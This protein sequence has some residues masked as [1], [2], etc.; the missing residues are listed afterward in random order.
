MGTS[1][2]GPAAYNSSVREQLVM[3]RVKEFLPIFKHR[4][5]VPL[6]GEHIHNGLGV[7]INECGCEITGLLRRT[8]R[9]LTDKH[10][11]A[12][13]QTMDKGTNTLI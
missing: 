1:S 7:S 5:N 11:L 9:L 13:T 2:K 12:I 8:I 10:D 3:I 4:L 6:H